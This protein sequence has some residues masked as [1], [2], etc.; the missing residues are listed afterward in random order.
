MVKSTRYYY[1]SNGYQNLTGHIQYSFSVYI[2]N[3]NSKEFTSV[4]E[5]SLFVL[6]HSESSISF[7]KFSLP[8]FAS[9]PPCGSLASL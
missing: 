9:T 2:Q 5:E 1:Y 7:L 6:E 4:K 8:S 3:L